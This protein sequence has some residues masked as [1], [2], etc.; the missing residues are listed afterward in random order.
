[1]QY[2]NQNKIYLHCINEKIKW[3]WDEIGLEHVLVR[4]WEILI[5]KKFVLS[6]KANGLQIPDLLLVYI[7]PLTWFI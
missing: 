5:D 1:M 6:L 3:F 7:N 4:F 2:S